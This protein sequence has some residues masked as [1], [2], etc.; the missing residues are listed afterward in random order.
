M[1]ALIRNIRCA[2]LHVKYSGEL[3]NTQHAWHGKN[4]IIL[5]LESE[6]GFSGFGEMYCDGGGSP[7]VAL[8]IL[9]HEIAPALRGRSSTRPLEILADLRRK[10]SLSA[11]GGA[12][13]MAIS[14][15]DIAMWDLL[16]KRAGL[17]LYRLLGGFS[18]R[19]NVY[20]SGGMY[21]PGI[22]PERLA[23]EMR[24]A[25]L[26]GLHG[27]KIK[28]GGASLEE[29]A[30]RVAKVRAAIGP[31]APLMVD[32]MFRPNV[33][34]AIKLGQ[35]LKPEN[36]HFFEA[37]TH[38]SD[39]TGWGTVRDACALALSGPELSD[40]RDLMRRLLQ[41]DAIDFLQFD[42]AIAGGVSEGREHFALAHAFGK[43]VTLHCAASAVAM[44]A[45]AQL[46]AGLGGCDSLE[47]HLMH[48]GM[49]ESLWDCGWRLDG[50]HLILPD[51][52]GL[53]VDPSD[54]VR[55]LLEDGLC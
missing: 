53:G 13:S 4:Y 23:E 19:V 51:R 17:P 11:R 32:A 36:L 27:A 10:Y 33:K 42:L 12:A 37:P 25:Q 14:A 28:V 26:Q 24:E 2:N 39:V 38:A 3:R 7:E 6:D 45:A 52:P 46:G 41:A 18:N 16:G 29:D 22:T 1:A 34:E 35:A 5:E 30:E 40:D 21:G 31:H 9:R 44:A 20:A 48:D 55:D 54:E 49:R 15:V 8:S 47:F 43:P 50:G